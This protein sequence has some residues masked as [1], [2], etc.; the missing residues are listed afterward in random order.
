MRHEETL[1]IAAQPVS[2]PARFGRISA[3]G[4]DRSISI[5]ARGVKIPFILA[6]ALPLIAQELEIR[7]V[8]HWSLAEVTRVAIEASGEFEYRHER[9][10]NPD[11]VFFDITG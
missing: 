1:T 4:T 2:G 10:S 6:F 8:R 5:R 9:L 3:G 7:D 11:R